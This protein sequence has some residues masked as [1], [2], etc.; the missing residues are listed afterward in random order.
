M[1]LLIF[2]NGV[3]PECWKVKETKPVGYC[4]VYYINDGTAWYHDVLGQ[5]KLKHRT[6]YFF[7]SIKCYEIHHDPLDPIDCLWWHIDLFPAVVPEL[8]ELNVAHDSSFCYLLET[9][10]RYL[11][12]TGGKTG[13]YRSLVDAFIEYCY[14][15]KWLPQPSG[16]IPEILEYMDAHYDQPINIEQISHHFN[17]SA[18][19]FIRMFQKGTNFTPYQYLIHRRMREAAALLLQ[20]VPVKEV[21]LAVGYQDTKVFAYRF[22]RIF[23]IPPSQYKDFYHPSA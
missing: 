11:M 5:R 9:L 13:S 3:Q 17:Y 14:D 6:L 20:N 8:I 16:K 4:R 7:P 12:E 1:N 2:G 15:Q 10:K 22:K 18:E 19:H 21:A 23:S